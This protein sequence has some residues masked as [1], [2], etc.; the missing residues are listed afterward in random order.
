M[1]ASSSVIPAGMGN[2]FS[3][4]M[5]KLIFVA[6]NAALLLFAPAAQ[7]RVI[8]G[9]EALKADNF[10]PLKGKRV[11]LVTNQTG[12][13]SSG[14]TTAEI[15]AAAKNF[16]L[17]A[18]FSP[19]HGLNGKAE[20]GELVGD[21]AIGKIPVISLYGE[22]RRPPFEKIKDLDIIVFDIQDIGTRF[23]TYLGTMIS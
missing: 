11:G 17:A 7:A 6:A 21:S 5:K 15:F 22:T 13:D 20:A 19:E 12:I 2:T 8:T 23:Y 3:A 9:L 10:A 18:V 4:G 16:T 14:R 1:E